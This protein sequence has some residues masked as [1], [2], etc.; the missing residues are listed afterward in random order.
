MSKN[1]YDFRR[2]TSR[3]TLSNPIKKNPKTTHKTSLRDFFPVVG[4]GA[5]AGGFEA[6]T[7][8]LKSL[9]QDTGM[10]FIFVQHL[11]PHHESMLTTLLARTTAMP[12][13]EVKNGMRLEPNRIYVMPSNVKMILSRGVLKLSPRGAPSAK[14]RPID[15]FFRSLAQD[16]GS[17]AIGIVLSGTAS[18]GALGIKTI[19]EEG[20]IT[21]AQEERSAKYDSMPRNAI[22]TGCVDFVLPPARIAEEIGRIA[23]HPYVGRLRSEKESGADKE[24]GQPSAQEQEAFSKIFALL[25]GAT[26]V[27]FTHYKHTTVRRRILRRLMLQKL[28]KLDDYIQFL[29]EKREEVLALYQDILIN[30]T[31][32]FR[33]PETFEALEKKV[34][35]R[36]VRPG[37]PTDEPIRIWVPGCSTGE[38]A[39]SMAIALVEYLA[40]QSSEVP[41]QIFATDIN[42][43]ALEKARR[44]VYP[45]SIS[46]DVPASLLK[47]Y[48]VK[49]GGGY[50]IV[51]RIRDLC[52]FSR[53]NVAKDP[54]FSK[55]DI[56]T[57][58]NLLIYLG[59]ILQ[60]RALSVFHYAL[61]P[62]GFLVLGNSETIG[63]FSDL[64]SHEDKKHKI[65][66]KKSIHAPLS[67]SFS[68]GDAGIFDR[69][70]KKSAGAAEEEGKSFDVRR[71]AD[72]ILLARYAPAGVIVN[73]ALHVIHFRG[74]T[75]DYLE[76]PPGSPDLNLYNMVREGLLPELRNAFT[77][78]KREDI[79]FRKEQI[80]FKEHGDYKKINLEVIPLKSPLTKERFFLVIFEEFFPYSGPAEAKASKPKDVS[81]KKDAGRHEVVRLKQEL[82]ATKDYLQTIIEDQQAVN[83]E[84]KSANEEIQSSNEEL[85]SMNE[86]LDTAK[87]E[88]QS[89]NEELTTVN[90]ELQTRNWELSQLNNDLNNLL[91]SV[92]IPIII[93]GPDLRIR[94]FTALTEKV[95]NL[96]PTDVGRPISDIKPNILIENFET[97]VS[98]VIDS[99]MVK[100]F[101]VQDKQGH[102]YSMRLRPYKTM[103]NKIDGVIIA[104]IDIDMLKRHSEE[105]R[106]TRNYTQAVFGIFKEPL[107]VLDRDLNIKMANRAFYQTFRI[108]KEEIKGKSLSQL[109]SGRWDGAKLKSIF[110]GKADHVEVTIDQP[111]LDLEQKEISFTA[112]RVL[113][114]DAQTPFILLTLRPRK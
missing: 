2:K 101:E 113:G 69:D 62:A 14:D 51:K 23:R 54:P 41:I 1:P 78:A 85:Q 108:A 75:K 81:K 98:E 28:E 91:A 66:S 111:F 4:I 18:D 112:S 79:P 110:Q 86:E 8:V 17:Q 34:F 38:E 56:I 68:K 100:E 61:K 90:E 21:F 114:E 37:I 67:L 13:I 55:M 3:K 15:S 36:L 27:D 40:Q 89:T 16:Q 43:A 87:E 6:F 92:N 52:I 64:F 7:R 63:S 53:Q 83:E 73:D 59:Q 107:L 33:D 84:I 5:S 65:Y 44:G 76:H 82:D 10:A 104:F 25:R 42:E 70:S 30:V 103:E 80:R 94:R 95:L 88:L 29:R 22:A 12:V 60:K 45:E 39:Y 72:R 106:E 26:G 49:A 46:L 48:F 31:S 97:I 35:S 11:D 57:C 96:I 20:G 102:W 93:L 50:Q 24:D 9:P 109:G 74:S 105:L 58:R 99:L 47:R 71:E 32:F 77:K 19:K